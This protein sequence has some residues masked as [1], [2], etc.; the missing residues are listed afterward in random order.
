MGDI[1]LQLLCGV[2]I[3]LAVGSL[4]YSRFRTGIVR[5]PLYLPGG[6]AYLTLIAPCTRGRIPLRIPTFLPMEG[7]QPN[8]TKSVFNFN[9]KVGKKL[10][11][12]NAYRWPLHSMFQLD[13]PLDLRCLPT[14]RDTR[15]EKRKKTLPFFK[16]ETECNIMLD[17][18]SSLKENP[19]N[20]Y[21]VLHSLKSSFKI[22]FFFV[23]F[24]AILLIEKSW[25]MITGFSQDGWNIFLGCQK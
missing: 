17:W 4:P 18:F 23:S 9:S 12:I 20:V 22:R 19:V 5:R 24:N 25:S 6:G 1:K 7:V 3:K 16:A 8:Q 11:R 2:R 21:Y 13:L 10:T 14:C 15:K